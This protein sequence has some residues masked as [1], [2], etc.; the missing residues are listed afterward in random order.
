MSWLDNLFT[1]GTGVVSG[2]GLVHATAGVIDG[3]AHLVV[4]A[5]VS[6]T[7][8]IQGAK[9][10]P[11]FGSQAM[12]AGVSTLAQLILA[13]VTIATTAPTAGQILTASSGAA[14]AWAAAPSSV[15][16]S[17]TM[18]GA[19]HTVLAAGNVMVRITS[20]NGHSLLMPASPTTGQTVQAMIEDT[21]LSSGNITINGN[22]ANVQYNTAPASTYVVSKANG[23]NDYSVVTLVYN[24]TFWKI[25]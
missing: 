2:T 17:E 1:K 21:S 19:D 13:G 23:W 9:V 11:N 25:S 7:A 12:T 8:G 22:G 6:L 10:V 4:D 15:Y 20:G 24:G 14:A 3:A 5:D 18:N 16:A